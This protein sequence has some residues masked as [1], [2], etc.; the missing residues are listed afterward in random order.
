MSNEVAYHTQDV[1]HKATRQCAIAYLGSLGPDGRS[2]SDTLEEG[3]SRSVLVLG[4][5]GVEEKELCVVVTQNPA[6][7]KLSPE[8][9]DCPLPIDT[10]WVPA[11][12]VKTQ[13]FV[14]GGMGHNGNHMRT[15]WAYTI[16]TRKWREIPYKKP[17]P[18]NRYQCQC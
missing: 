17:W 6:N 15:L 13:V 16:A 3:E 5:N 4:Q 10:R 14:F 8:V 2:P 12:R 18:P 9:I 1:G 11:C 7:G